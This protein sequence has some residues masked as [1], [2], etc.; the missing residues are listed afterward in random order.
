VERAI[1]RRAR[2]V[3]AEGQRPIVLR[4]AGP[5]ILAVEAP[6][7]EGEADDFPH[8]RFA[9]PAELPALARFLRADK[10]ALLEVHHLLGHEHAVLG[11]AARLGIPTSHHVHDY[12]AFCPRIS[13]LGPERRYCGEPSDPAQCDAC[14]LDA[15]AAI[16]DHTSTAALRARSA[17]ALA[18]AQSVVVPS[19]DTAVRLRRHFPGLAPRIAPHEDDSS[20][21]PPAPLRAGPPRRVAVVGAIGPEKGYD[22]LLACARDAAARALPLDFVIVGH[23][24]DDPRLLA[25]GRIFVTGR[26]AEAEAEALL[27]A[28]RA[29]LAFIPSIWPETWCFALTVAWRAGLHA[30][31]FDLGAQAERVRATDRGWVLPLGLPAPSINNALLSVRAPGSV[32]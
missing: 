12:A 1:R 29:D 27:R 5:G 3:A 21:P 32:V 8:L 14:V 17:A 20:L 26:Y 28:Q 16:A 22:V 2:Q 18:G 30:A 4:P 13:L 15:G 23:S 11:L 19:Q 9:I 7:A 6:G 10:P 25:T 31:V 24:A